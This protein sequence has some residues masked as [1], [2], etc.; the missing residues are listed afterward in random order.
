MADQLPDDGP[1]LNQ[2]PDDVA[3]LIRTKVPQTLKAWPQHEMGDLDRLVYNREAIYAYMCVTGPKV[4]VST[5]PMITIDKTTERETRSS[6]KDLQLVCYTGLEQK[7]IP[8]KSS[9]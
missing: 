5:L 4:P 8:G 3:N 2:L 7:S 9:H 6:T 1:C